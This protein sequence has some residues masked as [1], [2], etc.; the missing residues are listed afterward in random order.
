[1]RDTVRF[2]KQTLALAMVG[3]WASEALFWGFPPVPGDPLT[4][5]LTVVVYAG[6]FAAVLAAAQV[7]G[8]RGVPGLILGGALFGFLMEGVLV[9]TMMWG[10]PI[11]LVWVPLAW[12]MPLTVLGAIAAV[13]RGGGWFGI[14]LVALAVAGAVNAGYFPTVR[15]DLPVLGGVLAYQLPFLAL[16]IAGHL[17][18]D[19]LGPVARA[20]HWVIWGLVVLALGLW[21]AKLAGDPQPK[22]LLVPLMI[23]LTLWGMRRS[24]RAGPVEGR[25][26]VPGFGQSGWRA[27]WLTVPVVAVMLAGQIV[28]DGPGFPG[29]ELLAVTYGPV[30]LGLWLWALWRGSRTGARR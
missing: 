12:H 16:A 6:L 7:T 19:R 14:A 2:F 25:L 1:M 26:E 27:L 5:G 17:W 30:G 4:L 8:A 13:R 15:S 28:R 23:G 9:D 21:G 24:G 29:N 10:V 18:L 20:P 11:T 3:Y 22:R